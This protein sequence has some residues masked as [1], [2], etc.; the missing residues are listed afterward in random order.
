[1]R[2]NHLLTTALLA[3]GAL[4]ISAAAA[5][6]AG[7]RVDDFV[8]LD[9]AGQAH[10]LY[11]LSDAS[12]VVLMAHSAG[13]A[14]FAEFQ[15]RFEATADAFGDRGVE[16]LMVNS[17]PAAH[18]SL[19][20][21]ATDSA[22]PILLDQ[23][24]VVGSGLGLEAAG[25]VL[26][27]DTGRWQLRHRGPAGDGV[28]AAIDAVL[29]GRAVPAS[30]PGSTACPLTYAAAPEIVSYA[31]DIAP[32][33]VDNCV[34]CHREGGIGPWAMTGYDMVRGFAPMIRE[35]VRTKRMPPWHADPV[36]GTF[37]NDRS[38]ST[39]EVQKLVHWIE[40]G[41]PRGD[42]PD[43]LA[44]L[45]VE[46]PDWAIGEPDLII[47]IPAFDVPATGVVEYQYQRVVNPLDHDVWVRATEIL[48]GDR[49]A[50]H[51]VITTFRNRNADGDGFGRRGG[52]LGGY[53][54]G[55]EPRDAP[56]NTGTL[57]PAGAQ[58]IFQMHYTPYG[59]AVTDRSKLGLYFHDEPPKHRLANAVL[60]NT[61]IRI[62]PNTKSHS[63]FAERTF[64]RDVLLYSLLPHAHYRG[65]ASEFR[66]FYPDGSEELL[67]SVPNYDFNWQT[68]YVLEEPKVLPAG[69]RV[70][71]TT[72][73]DNSAQNPANPDPNREVPW[74]RQSW[75]EMLF[76]SLR[77]RDLDE[78]IAQAEGAT[79]E[80]D[81]GDSGPSD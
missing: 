17:E 7:D 33:L 24:G 11:Y 18:E 64:D 36:H 25:E 70:V 43:P 16:F 2:T 74:G 69:T 22:T 54:P 53:V 26:V 20:H 12:A 60:M 67:L 72:W 29:D 71:H 50:L 23:A 38:L 30:E 77:Y 40:A 48:P 32:M 14:E 13:C 8:L 15:A 31:H 65:K 55:A 79:L 21:E 3:A 6:Q 66:A 9:H 47:D 28:D 44:T 59:K 45:D 80:S 81:S 49:A 4:A 34:T 56:E 73:W 51:H 61:R 42:G 39:A 63:E 75:D 37:V 5:P 10:K 46:W 78:Q 58:I 1:M 52:G 27:V 41:A 76:G 35:V 19:R 57:L 68:T 62:P